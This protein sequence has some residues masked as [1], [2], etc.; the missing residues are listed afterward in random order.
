MLQNPLLHA[1]KRATL[2]SQRE[3]TISRFKYDRMAINISTLE[4]TIR[5]YVKMIADEKKK[6]IDSAHGQVPLPKLL[7]NIL[8]AIA[9]RQS[10]ISKRAQ[11][12][13]KHKLTFFRPRSDGYQRRRRTNR[14][15]HHRRS[16]HCHPIS[17]ILPLSPI[18]EVQSGLSSR[19]LAFLAKGPKY[20][21][22]CQSRFSRL[23]VD[24]IIEQEYQ[25]LTEAFKV[26]FNSN[27]MSATNT[28]STEFFAAVKHLLRQ[29]YTKSL[30]PQLFA[31]ARHDYQ[32]VTS[33]RHLQKKHKIVIQRTDKSKVFH[34]GSADSYHE[35]ALQ[36]MAKTNAYREIENGMNPCMDHLRQVLTFIDSLMKKKAIDLNIWKRYMRPNINTVELAHLYFLPKPHKVHL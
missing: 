4:E 30:S 9:A 15:C 29:S 33:I 34:L 2:S 1:D 35:R 21:P 27:C 23:P 18:V 32:M 12:I 26:G 20:V 28:R 25:Q 24:T 5:S 10:N 8:N 3:K 6:L 22:V 19:Q 13:T 11:T 14:G 31:R 17:P 36:Y 7:V 16:N